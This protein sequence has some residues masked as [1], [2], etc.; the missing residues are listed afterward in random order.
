MAHD[1]AEGT[2]EAGK[3]EISATLADLSDA[4][5]SAV[6]KLDRFG[7]SQM[8]DIAGRCHSRIFFEQVRKVVAV[9]RYGAG[10]L[11]DIQ[12]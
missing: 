4:E 5:G 7:D 10:D 9:H 2:I 3:A 11:N 12:F 6:Q 1:R 8:G